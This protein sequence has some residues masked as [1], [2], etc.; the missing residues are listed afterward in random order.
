[1]NLSSPKAI[2]FDWDNTLVDALPL[3]WQVSRIVA[4]T[5]LEN[6]IFE[7]QVDG[8]FISKQQFFQQ[9]GHKEQEAVQ[10]FRSTYKELTKEN[11]VAPFDNALSTLD[12]IKSSGIPMVLVSNKYHELLHFEV[13]HLE[14][15]S[16]FMKIVGSGDTDYDKPHPAPV[17]LAL[18]AINMEPHNGVWLIGDATADVQCALNTSCQPILFGNKLEFD[19]EKFS[20]MEIIEVSD[21]LN[22]QDLIAKTVVV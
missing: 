18:S 14:W 16:Y 2:I 9:F 1:M 11:G 10:L 21:H 22:L 13:Q 4:E 17:K 20:D 8:A 19:Q 15:E 12:L 3:I 6:Q 7:A 5:L